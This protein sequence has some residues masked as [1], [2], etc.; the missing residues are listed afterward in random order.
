[1]KM[2]VIVLFPLWSNKMTYINEGYKM[3]LISWDK[4]F[5][6]FILKILHF[7]LSRYA[8]FKRL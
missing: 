8:S 5:D 7:D 3:S 1:M 4:K 2:R 6:L